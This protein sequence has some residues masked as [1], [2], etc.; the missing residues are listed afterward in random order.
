MPTFIRRLCY[1][2]SASS[3][4]MTRERDHI[5]PPES[6]QLP[7]QWNRAEIIF[8]GRNFIQEADPESGIILQFTPAHIFHCI[9]TFREIY[10][11]SCRE[12]LWI[13]RIYHQHSFLDIAPVIS[14]SEEFWSNQCW[15]IPGFP[16][17]FSLIRFLW[18]RQTIPALTISSNFL[19]FTK[20]EK[21]VFY[22]VFIK[23][24]L[25]CRCASRLYK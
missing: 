25:S 4:Q 14:V 23:F 22:T 9:V 3:S 17:L 6:A 12:L 19:I 21:K 5:T 16:R 18:M 11:E 8:Y 7:L 20:K 2:V 1:I 13:W 15:I 10:M 24:L